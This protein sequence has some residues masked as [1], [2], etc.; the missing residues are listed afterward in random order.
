MFIIMVIKHLSFGKNKIKSKMIILKW[1]FAWVSS[2]LEIKK[3]T[4]TMKLNYYD[5]FNLFSD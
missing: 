5:A 1:I 3:Q 4:L 2:V